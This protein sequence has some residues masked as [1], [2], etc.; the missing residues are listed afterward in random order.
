MI[1]RT[2]ILWLF[3]SIILSSAASSLSDASVQNNQECA[4]NSQ[5]FQ[6]VDSFLDSLNDK[7]KRTE[8]VRDITRTVEEKIFNFT[9]I[10][11][12]IFYILKLFIIVLLYFVLKRVGLK[13]TSYHIDLLHKRQQQNIS[14][15]IDVSENLSIIETFTTLFTSIFTWILRIIFTLMFMTALG[16]NV[17]PLIYGV[18]F[19]GL[20]ISFA[21][22][23][24]IKDFING[25]LIVMD[26]SIAV[27]EIIE[28]GSH[29]GVVEQI[30]LRSLS[31]RYNSG[32]LVVIPFSEVSD[33]INYSRTF[34]KVRAEFII[35]ANQ[36]MTPVRAALNDAFEDFKKVYGSMV[37]ENTL[38]SGIS[39]A[40]EHGSHVYA[41]FKAKPD[42][43]SRLKSFF[44]TCIHEQMMKHNIQRIDGGN[45]YLVL[46]SSSLPAG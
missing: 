30:T 8:C 44:H 4:E 14:K 41:I 17:S 18:S 16:I 35:S 3:G 38:Y 19:L 7:T 6:K 25:I 28:T 42:P 11:H 15:N 32:A 31:L 24:V 26:G 12:F 40:T 1:K 45:E 36:D 43:L 39:H 34:S 46:P 23:S 5:Y 21:S 9:Q 22:Q 10:K 13:I 2:L 33:V 27:G 20:G 37:L 29:K